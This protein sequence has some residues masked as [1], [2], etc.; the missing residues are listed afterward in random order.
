MIVA[1]LLAAPMVLGLSAPAGARTAAPRLVAAHVT[2]AQKPTGLLVPNTFVKGKG[3]TQKYKPAKLKAHWGGPSGSPVCDGDHA[4]LTIT[5]DTRHEVQVTV[6]GDPLDNPIP[7]EGQ[8]IV[9]VFGSGK[10]T[11]VFGLAGSANTL[12]VKV[13]NAVT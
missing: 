1:A 10:A 13:T 6:G 11:V 5:N 2:G 4:S 8:L 12:T 9:C 3:P 7:G